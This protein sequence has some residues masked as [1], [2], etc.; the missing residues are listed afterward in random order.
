[1]KV[2]LFA[3][4]FYKTSFL[5]IGNVRLSETTNFLLKSYF[6]DVVITFNIIKQTFSQEKKTFK[7]L[8]LLFYFNIIIIKSSN[9][10]YC[11]NNCTHC[12]YGFLFN[13]LFTETILNY[14]YI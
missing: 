8:L 3:L 2:Y 6:S 13:N 1:M 9:S 12:C 7:T 11:I 5:R 4:Y 10:N 14:F